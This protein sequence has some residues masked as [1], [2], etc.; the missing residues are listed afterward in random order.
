MDGYDDGNVNGSTA[1]L[2]VP[3]TTRANAAMFG[4]VGITTGLIT[5]GMLYNA[6]RSENVFLFFFAVFAL[7]LQ[8][9][10]DITVASRELEQHSGGAGRIVRFTTVA[11]GFAGVLVAGV[12]MPFV[13][14][15]FGLV[16]LKRGGLGPGAG[17]F[18]Q[19]M[20]QRACSYVDQLAGYTFYTVSCMAMV[21]LQDDTP[22]RVTE[23][24]FRQAF[25]F[26]MFCVIISEAA[27]HAMLSAV[28]RREFLGGTLLAVAAQVVN[29]ACWS[30]VY[31]VYS[32]CYVQGLG[33]Q[34]N[35]RHAIGDASA[36]AAA[37]ERQLWSNSTG[38]P[39]PYLFPDLGSVA[40]TLQSS[41][42]CI[43]DGT[44]FE[45][46]TTWMLFASFVSLVVA[47]FAQ[48][49]IT[50]GFAVRHY[51]TQNIAR[52]FFQ[53]PERVTEADDVRVVAAEQG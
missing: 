23:S 37:W 44:V 29:L 7:F 49:V 38:V 1:M 13:A 3:E 11:A 24:D 45:A 4:H 43:A 18:R 32:D 19:Y 20:L 9:V 21:R 12:A 6:L 35:L 15:S 53:I 26:F 31:Y 50:I 14:K 40:A 2:E 17:L 52:L 27:S 16:G 10:F 51:G 47:K 22:H 33:T 5:L 41:R 30:Y 39:I 46:R 25:L 48:W 8:A 28:I 34:N 36:V 42:E